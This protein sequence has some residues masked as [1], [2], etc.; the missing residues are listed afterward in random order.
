MIHLLIVLC[1]ISCICDFFGLVLGRIT[2]ILKTMEG[3]H[4]Q[5]VDP[6]VNV[7]GEVPKTMD[8]FNNFM[9]PKFNIFT[10]LRMFVGLV[11]F[12]SNLLLP[13]YLLSLFTK[14]TNVSYHRQMHSY[15]PFMILDF[16]RASASGDELEGTDFALPET[17]QEK[18]GAN[19]T[20]FNRYIAFMVAKTAM[21][22]I[23]STFHAIY[24]PASYLEQLLMRD[25]AGGK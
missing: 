13:Y 10:I 22:A 6:A 3:D 18:T 2:T 21:K 19:L 14:M 20:S 4:L 8:M 16:K 1:V 9:M 17:E 24:S 11:S 25:K 5:A 15:T 23:Y 7:E 12:L